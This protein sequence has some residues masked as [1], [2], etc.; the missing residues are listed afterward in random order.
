LHWPSPCSA[1]ML[2]LAAETQSKSLG[3]ASGH[4]WRLLRACRWCHRPA[5]PALR[6][7]SDEPSV[8]AGSG[9]SLSGGIQLA[10]A[11]TPASARSVG[12]LTPLPSFIS[13]SRGILQ[14]LPSLRFWP[15]RA[16]PC[17]TPLPATAGFLTQL[18]LP[19]DPRRVAARTRGARSPPACP[20]SLDHPALR[21]DLPAFCVPCAEPSLQQRPAPVC[22]Q[23]SGI[24][25]PSFGLH[26]PGHF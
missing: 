21:W 16:S 23:R 11:S 15:P 12:R 26:K 6:L 20:P 13:R 18:A 8:A 7:T 25:L 22:A 4:D 2:P 14:D 17:T 19:A 5:L 24:R 1:L 3:P 9:G 10:P